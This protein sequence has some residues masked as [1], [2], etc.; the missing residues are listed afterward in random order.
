MYNIIFPTILR[1]IAAFFIAL[2]LARLTGR[3]LIAQMTFFDYVIAVTLGST[4]AN[5]AIGPL[6]KSVI[7]TVV[8]VTL[9]ALA[10]LSGFLHIKSF[11]VRKYLNSE[12]LMVIAN[13]KI[14][15]ENLRRARITLDEM[16]MMLRQKGI[17]NLSDAEFAM[18]EI[19][20]KMS[21]LPKSEKQPVTPAD[22]G[23]ATT[24]RG[25]SKD[26]IIDG[27][28]MRENLEDAKLD[29]DWLLESLRKYGAGDA[30]EVFYAGLDTAGNLFVSLK[31]K[32][33]EKSGKYGI[34]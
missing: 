29:E 9:A 12:P 1:T 32:H 19:D 31:N 30:K 23:I 2:I 17:F 4:T 33:K 21:V 26:L 25:L 27:K 10:V 18:V 28:I 11:W 24:Y 13:G 6:H 14:V 15:E 16:L 34:E 3:K 20:G 22:M 8:L 5:L 7:S